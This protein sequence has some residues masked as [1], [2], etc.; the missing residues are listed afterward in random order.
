MS[1]MQVRPRSWSRGVCA[2]SLSSI[3]RLQGRRFVFG[4]R[5]L[6]RRRALARRWQRGIRYSSLCGLC[7]KISS[8]VIRGSV[9]KTLSFRLQSRSAVIP[10]KEA[11]PLRKQRSIWFHFLLLKITINIFAI[12]QKSF[13]S[14]KIS[15]MDLNLISLLSRER[16]E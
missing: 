9:R 11:V 12:Y 4:W 3:P 5:N 8:S 13:Y 14:C 2:W 7:G 15:A 10:V 1:S 6:A 16:G